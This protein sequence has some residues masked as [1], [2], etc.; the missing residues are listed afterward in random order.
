M[1]DDV[2]GVSNGA[3]IMRKGDHID[4]VDSLGNLLLDTVSGVDTYISNT[5]T[6]PAITST[7]ASFRCLTETTSKNP[8]TVDIMTLIKRRLLPLLKLGM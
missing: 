5:S 1:Y 8:R 2:Y 4:L 7:K 6:V 3:A